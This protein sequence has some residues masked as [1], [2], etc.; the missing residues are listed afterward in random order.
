MDLSKFKDIKSLTLAQR[1]ELRR[2]LEAAD[3]AQEAEIA[4]K[5]PEWRK[6]V[7]AYVE[8]KYG[9]TLQRIWTASKGVKEDYRIYDIPNSKGETKE[10]KIKRLGAFSKD[11]IAA[12]QEWSGKTYETKTK[13]AAFL[14]KESRGSKHAAAAE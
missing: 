14:R 11:D 4:A 12:I 2:E 5:L 3:E 13:I 7:E 6:E 8:K 1:N 10:F 9:V